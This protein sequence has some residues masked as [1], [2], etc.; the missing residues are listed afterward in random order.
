MKIILALA[1][2]FLYCAFMSERSPR[3]PG[4]SLEDVLKHVE[5]IYTSAGRSPLDSEA[6]VKIMGYNGLNG[7][8]RAEFA[9]LNGY[10]ALAKSGTN[11]KIS[12]EAQGAIRPLDEADRLKH[13]RKLALTPSL[14]SEILKD[15]KD[16]TETVLATVLQRKGFTEDGA[17]RAAKVWK[18]NVEF[19]KLGD[20][21]YIAGSSETD[22]GSG[23]APKGSDANKANPADN[24]KGGG[25]DTTYNAGELPIPIGDKVARIPFPMTEDD[26]ELFTETL[27]LWKKKI[28]R[29]LTTIPPKVSLPAD[30]VWKNND[31][32]KPVR[33][34]AIAGE[35]DGELYYTSQDGTGIPASQLKF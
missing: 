26:F 30:A 31:T 18:E 22:K 16:C 9:A 23:G 1:S 14:F 34:V 27:K 33:I 15:H 20:Q 29:K 21:G 19:A 2:F 17:K 8:S 5:S 13:I 10:G 24:G 28:V 3:F 32:D 35:H 6:I 7:A 12:D 11:F 25:M 4:S